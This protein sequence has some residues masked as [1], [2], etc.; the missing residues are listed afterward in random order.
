MMNNSSLDAGIHDNSVGWQLWIPGGL[1]RVVCGKT[2]DCSTNWDRIIIY[3]NGINTSGGYFYFNAGGSY[4]VISDRRIKKDFQAI[5]TDKSI[6]F[7]KRIEPTSFC[8]RDAETCCEKQAD[9]T[10]K[11]VKESHCSCRQDGWIAQNVLEACEA[12]GVPK[13]VI[14]NWYDYEQELGKP[15]EERKTLLGVSDRPILSHTVNVV[16]HLMEVVDTLVKRDEVI[17][18][19]AK[20]LEEE[21]KKL[22]TEL[23]DY[24]ALTDERLNKLASLVKQLMA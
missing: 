17:V 18:H 20:Q 14:N 4:G 16:K 22:R 6:E 13:S 11:E 8:L 24:K 21:N 9:G 1:A 12:S 3:T 23:E 7:L 19:H 10:E 2:V 15:D 5:Q